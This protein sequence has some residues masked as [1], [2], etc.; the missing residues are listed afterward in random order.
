MSTN[1]ATSTVRSAGS[2][3][4]KTGSR[5]RSFV[6][7]LASEV[8]IQGLWAT[9]RIEL[10]N[11]IEPK[12]VD[13][14]FLE[15]VLRSLSNL[16]TGESA[17]A[18]N[19]RRYIQEGAEDCILDIFLRFQE[20]PSILEPTLGIFS[21]L[22]DDPPNSSAQR[23]CSAVGIPSVMLIMKR[24]K[25]NPNVTENSCKVLGNFCSG[26][27]PNR[28]LQET[29]LTDGGIDQVLDIM[30]QHPQEKWVQVECCSALLQL[31]YDCPTNRRHIIE[32]GGC[33]VLEM[34]LANFQYDSWVQ[35][36]GRFAIEEIKKSFNDH[37]IKIEDKQMGW[38]PASF[39]Q[40][41]PDVVTKTIAGFDLPPASFEG[42][43]YEIDVKDVVDGGQVYRLHNNHFNIRVCHGVFKG[44]QLVH[45]YSQGTLEA[46]KITIEMM[47]ELAELAATSTTQQDKLAN[48]GA[49]E[50]VITGM[51]RRP[52]KPLVQQH[53]GLVLFF[54]AHKNAEN[55]K[56]IKA[57]GGLEV[58]QAAKQNFSN[59]PWVMRWVRLAISEINSFS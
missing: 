25:N 22:L 49:L 38:L 26:T 1:L 46:P 18:T 10:K 48:H 41:Y 42:D 19:Q 27:P 36:Y 39:I 43:G 24:H 5:R 58:L 45:G 13:H 31:S 50:L 35:K 15:Y 40:K 37:V 52:R 30:R 54:L 6:D 59:K 56:K 53:G 29:I 33:E 57:C 51:R 20:F 16:A 2:K 23:K 17:G 28:E 21:K 7:L 55:A 12:K 32:N 14:E 34:A 4:G 8:D 11:K 9:V 47:E 44:R 3:A